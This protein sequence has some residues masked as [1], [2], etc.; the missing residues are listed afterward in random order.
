MKAPPYGRFST[1][2]AVTQPAVGE[3]NVLPRIKTHVL[4][5]IAFIRSNVP[6]AI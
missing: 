2:D 6:H 4:P 5:K 3:R 1:L